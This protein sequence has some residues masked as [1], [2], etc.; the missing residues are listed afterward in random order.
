MAIPM[1]LGLIVV[2]SILGSAIWMSG[3]VGATRVNLSIDNLQLTNVV[4]AG[5]TSGYA[6]LKLEIQKGTP[7]EDIKIN[8]FQIEMPLKRGNGICEGRVRS[9]GKGKFQISSKGSLQKSKGRSKGRS[10]GKPK[11]P[12]IMNMSAIAKVIVTKITDP[13]DSF[14]LIK[15]FRCSLSRIK[16]EKPYKK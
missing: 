14:R 10:K 8:P 4:E 7:L 5:I 2:A 12:R 6:R 13:S 11:I 9:I 16:R 15:Y 1:V 3:R